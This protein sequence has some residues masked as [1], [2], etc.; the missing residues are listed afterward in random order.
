MVSQQK[1]SLL[2][3]AELAEDEIEDVV[4]SSGSRDFIERPQGVVEIEHEHF[5]GNLIPDCPLRRC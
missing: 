4:A 1:R 5:V 3:D 2:A